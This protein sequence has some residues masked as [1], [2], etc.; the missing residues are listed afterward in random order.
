MS[1][2]QGIKDAVKTG[3]GFLD[4]PAARHAFGTAG[5]VLDNSKTLSAT[6]EILFPKLRHTNIDALERIGLNPRLIGLGAATTPVVAGAVAGYEGFKNQ[7][8]PPPSAFYDGSG[9]LR[10]V[11]DMGAGPAFARSV[12][13]GR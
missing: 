13:G 10:H 4:T 6:R 3:L 9:D 5:S 1:V 12:M 8:S 11:N 7:P 2:V